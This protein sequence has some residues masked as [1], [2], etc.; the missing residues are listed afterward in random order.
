[1]KREVAV[2]VINAPAASLRIVRRSA[3]TVEDSVSV[4]VK[5]THNT[6]IETVG[7]YVTFYQEGVKM[8]PV[9][10]CEIDGATILLDGFHRV[11]AQDILHEH[12]DYDLTANFVD[13]ADWSGVLVTAA[14]E[15]LKHGKALSKTDRD[16][17]MARY[18]KLTERSYREIGRMLGVQAST[19][20]RFDRKVGIRVEQE[21]EQEIEQEVTEREERPAERYDARTD[22]ATDTRA[23]PDGYV[24]VHVP[25]GLE[26]MAIAALGEIDVA[27]IPPGLD[28]SVGRNAFH[29]LAEAQWFGRVMVV[30]SGDVMDFFRHAQRELNNETTGV[31][32]AF[33]NRMHERWFRHITEEGDEVA[34]LNDEPLCAFVMGEYDKP[35]FTYAAQDFASMWKRI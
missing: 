20:M 3:L 35:E 33:P 27:I 12:S 7:R 13:V 31:V 11:A 17:A 10:V 25:A 2:S 32:F 22:F 24:S 18:L 1:M 34:F 29:S 15:N 8:P 21:I 5:S 16:E 4:R 14:D 9:T 30:A 23:E 19:V 6:D 28:T 26:A